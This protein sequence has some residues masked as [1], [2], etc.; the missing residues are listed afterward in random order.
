[1]VNPNR[2]STTPSVPSPLRHEMARGRSTENAA[3][4]AVRNFRQVAAE[5]SSRRVELTE[6]QHLTFSPNEMARI[7]TRSNEA[8]PTQTQAISPNTRP[9]LP[10]K[11]SFFALVPDIGTISHETFSSEE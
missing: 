11:E 1:M 3:E 4:V 8:T 10:W 6:T 2:R 5:S 9:R 7:K